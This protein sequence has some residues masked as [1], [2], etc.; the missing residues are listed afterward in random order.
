MIDQRKEIEHMKTIGIGIQD[1]AKIADK[2]MSI[3]QIARSILKAWTSGKKK[4]SVN[5]RE[6]IR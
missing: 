3:I 5:F 6:P 2:N 4:N 1:F